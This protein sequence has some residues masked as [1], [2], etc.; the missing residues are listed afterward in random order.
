M[1]HPAAVTLGP[2][3]EVGS[4]QRRRVRLTA[5]AIAAM[6]TVS[7]ALV[8]WSAATHGVAVTFGGDTPVRLP[9]GAL[10]AAVILSPIVWSAIFRSPRFGMT[11]TEDALV[12][13][14]WWRRLTFDR[15]AISAAEPLPGVMRLRDGYFS[16]RGSNDQAFVVWLWPKNPEQTEIPLGVTTGSWRATSIAAQRI[17]AWLGV[18]IDFDEARADALLDEE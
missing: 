4:F 12:V 15:A 17:N 16:G 7:S 10:A 5:V 1:T 3:P 9:I 11:L 14:S 18:E 8:V 13:E 2:I 6:A